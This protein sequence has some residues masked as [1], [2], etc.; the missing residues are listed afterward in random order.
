MKIFIRDK[1]DLFTAF[2]H[3]EMGKIF[4]Q[5]RTA[6]DGQPPEHVLALAIR[7]VLAQGYQQRELFLLACTEGTFA[8]A[9]MQS[10]Q[11]RLTALLLPALQRA[12]EQGQLQAKDSLLLANLMTGMVVQGISWW[13]EHDEP[14]PDV[15]A[16][17][18]LFLLDQG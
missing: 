18:V 1:D 14:G 7:S 16:E 11:A 17:S 8:H 9:I 4:E 2:V 6:I 15:M 10:A 5:I 12:Q 13:F 3:E